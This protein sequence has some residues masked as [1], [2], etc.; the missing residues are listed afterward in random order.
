VLRG[1]ESSYELGSIKGGAAYSNTQ[2]SA[3]Y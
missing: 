1:L 2:S 3:K